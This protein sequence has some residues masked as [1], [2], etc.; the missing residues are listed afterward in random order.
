MAWKELSKEQKQ[1]FI[2]VLLGAATLLY[3]V[4]VLFVDGLVQKG[5]F[6][7]ESVEDARAKLADYHARLEPSAR[8]MAQQLLELRTNMV[9]ITENHL[10]PRGGEFA[11]AANQVYQLQQ[12]LG[13]DITKE[14]I[15]ILPRNSPGGPMLKESSFVPYTMKA[16]FMGTF[17]E[18]ATLLHG[19]EKQYPY[20]TVSRLNVSAGPT[21]DRHNVEFILQWP[22]WADPAELA[23]L[24]SPDPG[25][26]K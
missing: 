26:P 25:K 20:A 2:L 8:K 1:K 7:E 23:A 15:G 18:T 12:R 9:N 22:A 17:A 19:L 6:A 24:Q 4:K 10:P 5:Q 14:D 16:T 11:W 13:L 3:A 21:P